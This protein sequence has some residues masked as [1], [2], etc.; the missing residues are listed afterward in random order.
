MDNP[1]VIPIS[2][3]NDFLKEKLSWEEQQA[4]DFISALASYFY[5]CIT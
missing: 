5:I 3:K 4:S 1:W 2:F